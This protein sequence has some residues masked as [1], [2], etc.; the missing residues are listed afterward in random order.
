MTKEKAPRPEPGESLTKRGE[1]ERLK[2]K[3][4]EGKKGKPKAGGG[5]R[6]RQKM[7][8]GNTNR[9]KSAEHRVARAR[10][11]VPRGSHTLKTQ[12]S[13]GRRKS[14][15]RKGGQTPKQPPRHPYK[16][17]EEPDRAPDFGGGSAVQKKKE[18]CVQLKR[19]AAMATVLAQPPH[20]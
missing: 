2:S 15:A 10:A 13:L 8:G 16:G 5:G 20:T 18:A 1:Q 17:V 11:W 9:Q 12:Q 14:G 6:K 4:V 3:G 19:Q 7:V